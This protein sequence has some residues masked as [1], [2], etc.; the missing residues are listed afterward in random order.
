[1]IRL[2]SAAL[3][4]ALSPLGAL[5]SSMDGPPDLKDEPG[6]QRE[7]RE[8]R[9]GAT[10]APDGPPDLI[11]I[12]TAAT[13]GARSIG[14][15]PRETWHPL[16]DHVE[17]DPEL[18]DPSKQP[19][20]HL[21]EAELIERLPP[22]RGIDG[23]AEEDL[24]PLFDIPIVLN[25]HVHRLIK[26]F[27]E[28]GG[29]PHFQRYLN[30]SFRWIPMM[31][32]ILDGYGLPRD[33]VYVAMIESGFSMHAYSHAHAVGPW[34]FIA[35]TAEIYDLRMD[36]WVDE[37]RDPVKATHAA[38][39]F[40]TWLYKEFE[41]WHLAWAG[42][43]GGPTR[44]RRNMEQTGIEDY[45]ELCEAGRL[46]RETCGYVPKIMAAAII[47]KL[48]DRFDFEVE[49]LPP[50]E[51][52][53]VE[54]ESP[55]E[56]SA[57]ADLL[58]VQTSDLRALNPEL[59]RGMTPPPPP[60]GDGYQ[61]R[62]PRGKKERFIARKDELEPSRYVAHE[63]H[64]VRGGDSFWRIARAHGTTVAAVTAANPGI[65]PQRLMPGM[66]I[67]VPLPPGARQ[68]VPATREAP[69][70]PKA[71]VVA[72]GNG[73]VEL[74]HTVRAGETLWS[75]AQRH[76]V[77]TDQLIS[78]NRLLASGDHVHL[79]IG[80][81]LIVGQGEG[82]PSVVSGDRPIHVLQAGETLW[83]LS[84]RYDTSVDELRA[85]NGIED[86]HSLSIGQVIIVGR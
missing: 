24:R 71:E 76:G 77:T 75:I 81:R 38:A 14:L 7:A 15:H 5:A 69:S 51:H 11:D 45:W 37:R 78:W 73:K 22:S 44:V 35:P 55:T 34:Q 17:H 19:L 33:L 43:N 54:L 3:A 85:L 9:G 40:M 42:Y 48:S 41:D 36:G 70:R 84:Q 65:D 23:L 61:L 52:E 56:L 26:Y 20:D 32:E 46:P 79:S 66:E 25:E 47:S 68:R 16:D 10:R 74:H 21:T 72:R 49:P 30:R 64:T 82:D 67:L 59:R 86:V 13:Q 50:F 8:V 83:Q 62:L 6:L 53:T 63:T 39:R 12:A 29:R 18:V 31:H 2:V 58:V 4:L 1:M 60:G 57:I 27:S 80:Q 28:G